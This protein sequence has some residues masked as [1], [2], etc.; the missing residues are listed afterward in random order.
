VEVKRVKNAFELA[1]NKLKKEGIFIRL[2][3]K[4]IVLII[5]NTNPLLVKKLSNI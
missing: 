4:D 5:F 2:E 3:W 1:V